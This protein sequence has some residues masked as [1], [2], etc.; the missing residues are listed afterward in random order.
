MGIRTCW[1]C[2]AVSASETDQRFADCNRNR[3]PDQKPFRNNW[4]SIIVRKSIPDFQIKIGSR[5]SFQNRS[6]IK[7]PASLNFHSRSDKS[8]SDFRKK[9]DWQF[10]DQNRIVIF[11][12][13]S[14]P[15][16]IF[17]IAI[18]IPINNRS[19]I[20]GDRFSNQNRVSAFFSLNGYFDTHSQECPCLEQGGYTLPPSPLPGFRAGCR[21]RTRSIP[22]ICSMRVRGACTL[23]KK[24]TS[25]PYPALTVQET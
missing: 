3:D 1:S 14:D 17:L 16:F 7:K 6:A 24:R 23:Q 25:S 5:F 8:G 11:I 4:G 18:M 19:G 15:E 20:I 21:K 2:L 22:P 13:K 12:L 9:I 10:P